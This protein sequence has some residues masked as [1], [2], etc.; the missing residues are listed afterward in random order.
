MGIVSLGGPGSITIIFPFFSIIIPGA[1]PL[2]LYSTIPFF[3]GTIACFTLF[4]VI[5]LPV[6][7]KYFRILPNALSSRISL[8]PKYSAAVSFVRSSSVGPK[9][10]VVI[11]KSAL[12][13]A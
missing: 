3:S 7:S 1:V 4:S 11:I 8:S 2:S 5:T 12:E 6:R 13:K 9:P 10:P